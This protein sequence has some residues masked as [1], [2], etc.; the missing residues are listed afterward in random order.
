MAGDPAATPPLCR[1]P[2]ACTGRP[3]ASTLGNEPV[4]AQSGPGNL[5]D[6]RGESMAPVDAFLSHNR[7]DKATA[8]DLGAQL[9]LAGAYV[10]FDDWEVCAGESIVGRVNNALASVDVVI[11]L[12]S[13][14]AHCSRWVRAELDTAISRGIDEETF[15]VITVRL[16]ETPLPALLRPLKWV[17]LCDGDITRA[18]NDIMG[19]STD[20]DRLRAIQATLDHAGIEIRSF[21]GYGPV[22]CC[23]RCGARVD[24]LEGWSAVDH[25]RDDVYAGFKCL[26]CGFDDGGEI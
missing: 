1:R 20:Q 15:R 24:R 23:P 10:W 6:M 5:V 9:T 11:L 17:D 12:W 13:A 8:R 25:H 14:T 16:D 22:V 2:P 4:A 18:V 7:G 26:D 3:F 21:K 19:F